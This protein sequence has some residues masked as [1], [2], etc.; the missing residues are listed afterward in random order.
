MTK[1]AS[2]ALAALVDEQGA[3]VS[4]AD[5][6]NLEIEFARTAGR[7]FV[8]EAGFGF[9]LRMRDWRLNAEIL[10]HQSTQIG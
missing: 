5:C 10:I 9:V 2:Q 4:S 8:D 6:S 7:F 3:L 1:P